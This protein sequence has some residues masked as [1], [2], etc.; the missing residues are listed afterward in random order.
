MRAEAALRESEERRELALEA[1]QIG[2]VRRV[3]YEL[4]GTGT[5]AL[6]QGGLRCEITFPLAPGQ[7][8]LATDAPPAPTV[9]QETEP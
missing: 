3:P 8:I 9:H 5:I 4:K 1:T 6:R 2:A 7:S